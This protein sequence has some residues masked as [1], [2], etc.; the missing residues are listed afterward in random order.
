LILLLHYVLRKQLYKYIFRCEYFSLPAVHIYYTY[1]FGDSIV[2]TKS[3]VLLI[4]PMLIMFY[5]YMKYVGFKILELSSY[6][7]VALIILYL[8]GKTIKEG[9]KEY[10]NEYLRRDSD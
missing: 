3:I 8:I 10:F 1:I 2:H 5:A 6:A 9:L 4:T 7:I